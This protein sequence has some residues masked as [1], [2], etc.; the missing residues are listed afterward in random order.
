MSSEV[1]LGQVSC[2]DRPVMHVSQLSCPNPKP[3]HNIGSIQG[4]SP[5]W[6]T[7]TIFPIVYR[8]LLVAK[9]TEVCEVKMA[10]S[11]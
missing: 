2:K 4:K 7:E 1:L 6:R 5:E 8:L 10:A 9:A 11:A 3:S